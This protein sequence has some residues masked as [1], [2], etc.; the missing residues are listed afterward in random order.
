MEEGLFSAA[1]FPKSIYQ[2]EMEG[3]QMNQSS[4]LTLTG[5]YAA[6]SDVET[7]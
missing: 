2:L 1:L 4:L 3:T 5:Y 7:D 6:A